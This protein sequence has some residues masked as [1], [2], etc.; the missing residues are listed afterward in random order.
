[1]LSWLGGGGMSAIFLAELDP[2]ARASI[3]SPVTPTRLAIK[4]LKPSMQ[5]EADRSNFDAVDV[6][7]RESVALGRMMKR[8]PPTEFVV[9]VSGGGRM[10]G[11]VHDR[12]RI[13]P[14]LAIEYVDGGEEGETLTER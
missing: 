11:D 13:L 14:W 10:K 2:A 9:Q 7:V 12:V 4:I 6:F 3:I 8:K 1:L 5:E